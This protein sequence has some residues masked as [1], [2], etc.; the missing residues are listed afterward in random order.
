MQH[1]TISLARIC[2]VFAA[3]GAV[4]GATVAVAAENPR[5]V[6]TLDFET[7]YFSW[8][9]TK[10]DLP[11]QPQQKGTQSYTPFS[12]QTVGLPTDTWK[13]ELLA[14]GGYVDTSRS[15][16]PFA[17]QF[18]VPFSTGNV[19]TATDTLL[20][21]T[22]TYLGLDGF[23]PFYTL[24]L[25]LPTGETVLLGKKGIARTDPDLV[26]IP[27]FG[28][29][30]NHGH[31]VGANIPVTADLIA[32]FSAGYTNKG[33]YSREVY[34]PS[35]LMGAVLPFD[36]ASPG[37]STAFSANLAGTFGQF[38]FNLSAATTFYQPDAV[39]GVE[40]FENGRNVYLS[41]YASYRW[42]EMW[43]S[44][45]TAS[46]SHTQKMYLADPVTGTL[47]AEPFN[48]NSDL[49]SA[50]FAHALAWQSFVF[51]GNVGYIHRNA[52][53]YSSLAQSFVPAKTK[54]SAGGGVKYTANDNLTLSVR[55][56]RFWIEEDVK[57]DFGFMV[58]FVNGVPM[59]Y[60]GWMV[61]LGATTTF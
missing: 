43:T 59:S 28:E 10:G 23:Q 14:R 36:R 35:T 16:L 3:V 57:P 26:D 17:P 5:W 31:T 12:L 29:G 25:N 30:Y 9:R 39:N 60:D 52:N 24:S 32:T 13:I 27:S 6:T 11:G 46:H 18:G 53:E 37:D 8:E 44:T 7:R 40:I 48:S 4:Y 15:A 21:G 19:A 61:A 42:D 33:S 54:W 50:T 47:L 1:H 20:T 2:G 51:N 49:V 22:V 41:G 38:S 58:G 56:E 55:A 45:A 34:D